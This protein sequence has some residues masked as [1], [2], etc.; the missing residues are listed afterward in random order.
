[1]SFKSIRSKLLIPLYCKVRL[2]KWPLP[3]TFLLCESGE[4]RVTRSISPNFFHLSFHFFWK[5]SSE[6]APAKY[7]FIVWVWSWEKRVTRSNGRRTFPGVK[8]NLDF[9]DSLMGQGCKK[10]IRWKRKWCHFKQIYQY[11]F[12]ITSLSQLIILR[13]NKK[14][15]KQEKEE[16]QIAMGKRAFC[17]HIVRNRHNFCD[18]L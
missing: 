5:M 16:L 9:F 14:M 4:K 12:R 18:S 11:K 2:L 8:N 3:N 17:R 6:V 7:P 1:M 10:R 15:R 13:L